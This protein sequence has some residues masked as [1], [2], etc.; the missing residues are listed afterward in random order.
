MGMCSSKLA[1]FLC[2][3]GV[4]WHFRIAFL[5]GGRIKLEICGVRGMVMD[6]N[7]VTFQAHRNDSRITNFDLRVVVACTGFVRSGHS[8]LITFP[9][10]TGMLLSY[11]R[12]FCRLLI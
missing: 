3:R 9:C 5:L 8:S 7:F 12:G 4:L 10:I 1:P 2:D 11:G 6:T